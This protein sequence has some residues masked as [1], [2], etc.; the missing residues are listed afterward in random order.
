MFAE[1]LIARERFLERIVLVTV[2]H[3]P[4]NG[5]ILLEIADQIF[6]LRAQIVKPATGQVRLRIGLRQSRDQQIDRDQNRQ[7]DRRRRRGVGAEAEVFGLDCGF[8]SFPESS[9]LRFLVC[10]AFLLRLASI[11]F[12][13]E[14]QLHLLFSQACT[15]R[16]TKNAMTER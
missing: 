3:D 1:I 15:V 9:L 13:A 12:L 6:G 10:L 4:V 16:N 2:L 7:H 11:F 5:Y 8:Q 14:H